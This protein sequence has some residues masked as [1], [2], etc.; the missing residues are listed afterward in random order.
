MAMQ[1]DSDRGIVVGVDDMFFAA[2]IR[3]AADAVGAEIIRIK[4]A[5]EL[6]AHVESRGARLVIIDLNSK[7]LD[8]IP[9]IRYLKSKAELET[10]PII[11]FLSHVQ[12]D[13]MN[14][15]QQAGCDHVMPRSAFSKRLP[16]LLSGQL[17]P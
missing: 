15:A 11:G 3:A 1:T 14:T 6:I 13:L 8:P 9:T 16:E 17:K 10:I 5:D 2:K 12:V 4:A 7:R